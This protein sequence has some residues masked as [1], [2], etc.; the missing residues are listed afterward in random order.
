MPRQRHILEWGAA[1]KELV[2]HVQDM[3]QKT[4]VM[5]ALSRAR[6]SLGLLGR[7]VHVQVHGRQK[8]IIFA[9]PTGSMHGY[10]EGVSHKDY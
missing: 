2:E 5:H 1:E 6:P 4:L 7:R 3:R 10:V 9:P 8:M